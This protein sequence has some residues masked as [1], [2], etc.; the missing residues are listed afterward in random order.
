MIERAGG[1]QAVG[2]SIG[3]V[4]GCVTIFILIVSGKLMITSSPAFGVVPE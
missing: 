4:V 3:I 1:G 2:L